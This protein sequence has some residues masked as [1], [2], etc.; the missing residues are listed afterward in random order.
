MYREPVKNSFFFWI[1][2]EPQIW[3]WENMN[4]PGNT[5]T[6]GTSVSVTLWQAFLLGSFYLFPKIHISLPV[7]SPTFPY[8]L[9]V[10]SKSC[11]LQY[12]PIIL[13]IYFTEKLSLISAFFSMRDNWLYL[14]GSIRH[15]YSLPLSLLFSFYSF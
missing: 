2:Q 5:Y 11:F 9:T 7:F 3:S 13:A 14:Q 15:V 6:N 8:Y 4:V 12:L 1:Q 10:T